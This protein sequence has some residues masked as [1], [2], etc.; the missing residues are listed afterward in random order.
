M[1]SIVV[2]SLLLPLL[3]LMLPCVLIL[4]ALKLWNIYIENTRDM[5][6]SA[7]LPDGSMGIPFIGETVQFMFQGVDFYRK[8]FQKHGP[9]FK[10]HIIGKPTI[11]VIG[12]ENVR[13]ILQGDGDIVEQLYPKTIRSLLTS[14]SE[15]I[16]FSNGQV[17]ERLRKVTSK[18]F[19]ISRLAS[20][21]PFIQKYTDEA[22]TRWCTGGRVSGQD[23]CRSLLFRIAGKVMCNFDYDENETRHLSNV[24][25]TM[26]DNIFS[27]PIDLPG[28][29]F[30]KA[31]KARNILHSKVEANLRDKREH[32]QCESEFVDALSL[33]S[34]AMGE[35]G[36]PVSA[37]QL[38]GFALELLFAGHTTSAT[39]ATMMLLY[40]AKHPDVLEKVRQEL[41]EHDLENN[42]APLT[43]EAVTKLKYVH[44]VVK[45]VLR[46]SP[47]I[48]AG[49]RRVIKTFELGGK[50]I[51]AGW[52]VIFSIRETQNLAPNYSKPEEF[53]PERFMPDRQEDKKG[54]RFSYLPF[55]GG[56]RNCIGKQLALL[57]LKILLIQ[58]TKSCRWKLV[59]P[60]NVVVNLLPSPYPVDG[61]PLQFTRL[62]CN[63]NRLDIKG[64]DRNGDVAC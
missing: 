58:L 10:T 16:L 63:A 45:E 22:A 53:D 25:Q 9:I 17:H 57:M 11:R 41:E 43:L 47:P 54:D 26:V 60:E 51:P 34:D 46:I 14:N 38:K 52:T 19:H 59:D 49:F 6:C 37:Q 23:E 33:I 39:A 13:R 24:Y 5:N 55:S 15:S 30:N 31:L 21:V 18:V 36:K 20:Y 8:K 64:K 4:L 27:L 62:D 12:T 42:V 50:Q 28:S 35:C 44:C 29:G 3:P 1:Q 48:G 7:P 61:L 56:P 2:N 32:A 40:L